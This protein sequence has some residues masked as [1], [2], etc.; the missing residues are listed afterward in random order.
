MTILSTGKLYKIDATMSEKGSKT[1][2]DELITYY[3]LKDDE[4]L[5]KIFDDAKTNY[6]FDIILAETLN[7]CFHDEYFNP[8]LDKPYLDIS[9]LTI[10]NLDKTK[11]FINLD[12][13]IDVFTSN[14]EE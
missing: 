4:D 9:H 12:D 13:I 14:L 1:N 8:Y 11:R 6:D 7:Y 5:K 2:I 3:V 10:T